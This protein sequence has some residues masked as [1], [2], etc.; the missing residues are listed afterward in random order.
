M[1]RP[2]TRKQKIAF[3]FFFVFLSLQVLTENFIGNWFGSS[4]FIWHLGDKIFTKPCLWLND[5]F[6]HF[7]Y[8][9]QGWTSFSGALHTIR[10]F[11]YLLLSGFVCAVWTALDKRRPAYNQLLYWF[12]R[13]LIVALSCIMFAYGIVKIFP[14]QMIEPSFIDLNKTVG[15][16]SP[17][18]L[19]WTAYGYGQ[20]YQIFSGIFEAAGA[21]MILFKRTRVLG[22]LIIS[23]VMIN[24]IL[25]NYTF[26]VGVLITSFYI[27]LVTLFLLAP[28]VFQL[29][30]FFTAGKP[31][32]LVFN[33]YV[34]QKYPVRIFMAVAAVLITSSFFLNIERAYETYARRSNVDRTREYSIVENDNGQGWK[35]WSERIV[36]GKRLVTINMLNPDLNKTFLIDQDTFVHQIILKP[37]SGTDT[38]SLNFLYANLDN[39]NWS[40]EG[41]NMKI[42]LKRVRPDTALNLLKIKRN[43]IV[44]DDEPNE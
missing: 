26:H 43:I 7:K 29:W 32:I 25:L 20:P 5:H 28:F 42:E 3:R 19:L 13:C 33:E 8:I 17:F 37:F 40:L 30:K 11:I 4:L 23:A 10:D 16:L 21:I 34:P 15:E 22:L 2:W 1:K 9:D 36:D 12:S 39:A 6:F 31:A 41:M 35:I 18:D 38:T 27:L 24:V 14:V 44:F